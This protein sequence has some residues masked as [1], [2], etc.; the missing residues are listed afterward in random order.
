MKLANL[1]A[2]FDAS[3]RAY[4]LVHGGRIA[5]ELNMS[6]G[7]IFIAPINGRSGAALRP[8][9]VPRPVQQLPQGGRSRVAA[10]KGA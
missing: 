7:A 8:V 9:S 2:S 3:A 4:L 1:R 5:G 6:G 10:P